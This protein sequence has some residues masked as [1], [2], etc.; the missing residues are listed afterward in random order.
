VFLKSARDQRVE[1]R[2]LADLNV[3][4]FDE[5][6]ALFDAKA[7]PATGHDDRTPLMHELRRD[8]VVL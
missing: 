7:L 4:F 5:T 2:R 3:D 6:A 8:G 1:R